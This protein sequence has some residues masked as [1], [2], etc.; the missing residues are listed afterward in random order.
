LIVEKGQDVIDIA[1][2]KGN[3]LFDAEHV[4]VERIN[5]KLKDTGAAPSGKH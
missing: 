5:D 1:S 2:P 3:K 4:A